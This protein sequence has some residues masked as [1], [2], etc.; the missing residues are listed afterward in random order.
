MSTTLQCALTKPFCGVLQLHHF[1]M[2]INFSKPQSNADATVYNFLSSALLCKGR[3]LMGSCDVHGYCP[4]EKCMK[5]TTSD[6][7]GYKEMR[8]TRT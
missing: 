7:C 2:C 3:C 1:T 4:C 8:Q 5:L 6:I